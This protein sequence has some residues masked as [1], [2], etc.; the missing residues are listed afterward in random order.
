MTEGFPDPAAATGT[1]EERLVAF[2][3]VRDAIE[4]R[5][6]ALAAELRVERAAPR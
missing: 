6:A 3:A 5:M 4:A 1:E 2:R